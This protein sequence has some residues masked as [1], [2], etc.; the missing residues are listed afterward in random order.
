[1]ASGTLT[2]KTSAG[3]VVATKSLDVDAMASV[4]GSLQDLFGTSVVGQIIGNFGGSVITVESFGTASTLNYVAAQ[5]PAELPSLYVPFFA[6]GG[7]YETDLNL[8][9]SSDQPVALSAQL[10]NNQGTLVAQ[11]QTVNIPAGQQL[12]AT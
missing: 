3:A 11:A 6:T 10:I 4:S 12:A 2:L 8:I 7:G 1:R 9:N 5:V